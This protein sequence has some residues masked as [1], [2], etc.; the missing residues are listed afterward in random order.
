MGER[1]GRH[2]RRS[3]ED[4]IGLEHGKWMHR[5]D[6]HRVEQRVEKGTKLEDSDDLC[7]SASSAPGA[8]RAICH[9]RVAS[10]VVVT[11]ALL[12]TALRLRGTGSRRVR[13]GDH[14]QETRRR[15]L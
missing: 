3:N 13:P 2:L 1:T 15:I 12:L 11:T 10:A 8:I 4:P 6:K 14:R 9:R 7:E 5:K